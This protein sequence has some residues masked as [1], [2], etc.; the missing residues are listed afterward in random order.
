MMKKCKILGTAAAMMLVF[1]LAGCENNTD[2]VDAL[3]KRVDQMEQELADMEINNNLAESSQDKASINEVSASDD[4]IASL[5]QAVDD[6]VSKA[7][8]AKPDGTEEEKMEQFFAL[9]KDEEYGQ[10]SGLL[11]HQNTST[12]RKTFLGRIPKPGSLEEL[13]DKLDAAEDQLE[14]T[15]GIDD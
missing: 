7:N 1:A 6:M 9:K 11:Y 3:K 14:W 12:A 2:D 4:S 15:F 5:T 8:E 13:E 10:P